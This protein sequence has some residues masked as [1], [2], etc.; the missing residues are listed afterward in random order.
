MIMI[1]ILIIIII[2]IMIKFVKFCFLLYV[3]GI[4]IVVYLGR[5]Y[6]IFDL[7]N[8]KVVLLCLLLENVIISLVI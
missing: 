1:V 5:L 4:C 8:I 7:C 3:Y 6:I 2:I